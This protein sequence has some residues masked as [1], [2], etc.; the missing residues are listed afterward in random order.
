M[1]PILW[2]PV[3]DGSVALSSKDNGG[4]DLVSQEP[5]GLAVPGT[6]H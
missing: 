4:T 1:K 5:R 6:Q 3:Q 2:E